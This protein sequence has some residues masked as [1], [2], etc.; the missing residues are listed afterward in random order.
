MKSE[1]YNQGYKYGYNGHAAGL[2]PQDI[3]REQERE[4]LE[5]FLHGQTA[6]YPYP[7][8]RAGDRMRGPFG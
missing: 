1:F 5:G 8:R 7:G 2:R 4:W 6:R 3:T